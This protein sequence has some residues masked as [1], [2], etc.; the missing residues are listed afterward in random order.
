MQNVSSIIDNIMINWSQGVSPGFAISIVNCH[1][2]SNLYYCGLANLEH[3]IPINE[4]TVFYLCS[5]SKQFTAFCLATLINENKISL[6]DPVRKFLPQLPE[7]IY[8]TITISH[9]A[10]MTSG[11][12]EWYD[13]MEYSGSYTDE[14]PWRKSILPLLIRQQYL[15]FT[16]GTQFSYCNTNYVLLTLIIE[17]ITQKSLAEYARQIIFMPLNMTS[18]C[19]CEDNNRVIPHAASG[20]Y[21]IGDN[22]ETADKLPPLIGAGGVYSTL[23]DLTIWL[24]AIINK[25]WQ[26]QIFRTLFSPSHFN[27]GKLNPYM[28]G[29]QNMYFHNHQV[30]HH[31]GAVPGFF[32]HICYIPQQNSGFIWLANHNNIKPDK[33][34]FDLLKL[35]ETDF[36]AT[37]ENPDHT[38][39][40]PDTS[41]FTGKY[42]FLNEAGS[43]HLETDN[44]CL[45][46]KGNHTCYQHDHNNVFTDP[47]NNSQMIIL[48]EYFQTI[49]LRVISEKKDKFLIKADQLPVHENIQQY[50]DKYYSPTLDVTYSFTESQN[51]LYIDA[52]KKFSG[53]DL[54]LIAPDIFLSPTKGMKIRFQRDDNNQITS[55]FLDS[56]RSQKFIFYKIS[57]NPNTEL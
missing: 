18:T 5:L 53:T 19:F 30:I 8:G 26:F 40:C 20:Y 38:P 11:I 52:V 25:Q 21:K 43:L 7:H 50:C 4:N 49:I 13:I 31:G 9:L 14:Y 33:I 45:T 57:T 37:P 32:T 29:F 1:D 34:T 41:L 54:R 35:L 16:P 15:S 12:H 10:H 44:N 56:F 48:A 2:S 23:N 55:L 46:I 36:S 51:N 24:K 42:I 28:I 22:I 6:S 27:N 39:A 47:E 3:D 17:Q